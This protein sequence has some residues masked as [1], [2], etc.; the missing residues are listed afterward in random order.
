MRLD[1]LKPVIRANMRTANRRLQ[2]YAKSGVENPH[3]NSILEKIKGSPF[4]DVE[5]NK[6][7]MGGLSKRDLETLAEVQKEIKS[8]DTVKKYTKKVEKIYDANK[9]LFKDSEMPDINF[10]ARAIETF[11][12]IHGDKYN[13]WTDYIQQTGNIES[14]GDTLANMFKDIL[15]QQQD[16]ELSQ[17]EIEKLNNDTLEKWEKF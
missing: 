4:Y 5:K 3:L 15:R 13:T 9:D 16:V 8:L 12:S 2:Q 6:L 17:H 11:Q 14:K 10:F 1:L 7:R